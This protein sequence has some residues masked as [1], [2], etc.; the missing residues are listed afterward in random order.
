MRRIPAGIT[1]DRLL[2]DLDI[3]ATSKA[4]RPVAETGVLAQADGGVLVLAMADDFSPGAAARLAAA[5][6]TESVTLETRRFRPQ[7]VG[8]S[9]ASSRSTKA[10]ARTRGRRRSDRCGP[11]VGLAPSAAGH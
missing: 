2:G 10:S 4:G 5:L 9:L 3:A 11:M 7:A 1:D 8:A 6:D